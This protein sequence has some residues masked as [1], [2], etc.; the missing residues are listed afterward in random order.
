MLRIPVEGHSNNIPHLR[1]S[2][3]GHFLSSSSIDQTFRV[4]KTSEIT[5]ATRKECDQ[6]Y[7]LIYLYI[8]QFIY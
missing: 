5:D 2:P 6:I 3:R 7:L 8:Y 4:W 1:F